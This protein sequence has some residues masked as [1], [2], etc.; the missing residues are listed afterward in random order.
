MPGV[1]RRIRVVVCRGGA[2]VTVNEATSTKGVK[3]IDHVAIAVRSIDESRQTFEGIYG[4]KYLG[5]KENTEQQY[6]VAYFLM[7]ESLITMLEGTTPESFVTQH[8]EKRGEGIQHMGVEVDDLD[9]FVEQATA[10]GARISNQR[11]LEGIRKEA[12]ISPKSA[13]GIILQPIEWLGSLKTEPHH[14]RIIKAG[15]L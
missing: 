15:G 8:I 6:I 14:E 12:L 4:A 3:K 1:D 11:T 7:G 10:Q 2:M 13:F 5:Q 9:A